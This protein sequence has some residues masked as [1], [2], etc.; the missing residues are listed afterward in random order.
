LKGENAMVKKILLAALTVAGALLGV[1]KAQ[2][3]VHV[4]GH[5]R[6]NGTYVAPHYRTYPDHNFNNNW[7]T[8]PNV[9]PYTGQISTHHTPRYVPSYSAPSYSAPSY[10]TRSYGVQTYTNPYSPRHSQSY[11]GPR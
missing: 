6:S 10:G 4:Q 8:Y 3:Q 7:S 5:Y 11:G 9:N 1:Q 2:A